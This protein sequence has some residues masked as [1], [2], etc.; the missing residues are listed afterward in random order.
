MMPSPD[1]AISSFTV[2]DQLY[3]VSV[4]FNGVFC[5]QVDTAISSPP[6][7][8]KRS[9]LVPVTERPCEDLSIQPHPHHNLG[10]EHLPSLATAY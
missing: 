4:Y 6:P 9:G 5:M 3:A 2:L 8:R 1:P 10:S 7:T